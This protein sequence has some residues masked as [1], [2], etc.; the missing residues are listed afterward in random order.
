MIESA[1][2][3][4]NK[5]IVHR[6]GCKAEGEPLSISKSEMQTAEYE[7]V[8]DMLKC[9]FFKPFK[10]EA[11]FN[12]THDEGIEM[13]MV[14]NHVSEIFDNP[15]SFHEMSINIASQLYECSTHAKIKGGEFYMAYFTDCIVDGEL[16]D[17]IGI[18]KSENKEMFLKVYMSSDENIGLGAQEGISIRKLDKGCIIFN[19]ER[20]DGYR[21]CAVDNINKGQE[22]RFWM[23]DFLGLTPRQDNYFFTDNYMQLCKGFVKDVFNEQNNVRRTDQIELIN[24]SLD[25]FQHTPQFNHEDFQNRVMIEPDIMQAFD[26]YK[27]RY[28]I[29]NKVPKP[30]PDAFDISKDAVKSEKKHFK[31]IIKLD[32]NF[33]I[34]I[35]GG[36]YMMEKDY[37]AEKDLN[38]YKLYF[39]SES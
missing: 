31:T 39:K 2:A 28:E 3:K 13:N 9:F 32:K 7:E 19:V 27:E 21:V 29:D 34:Y 6:I 35:H 1:N 30:L 33:H 11:Y 22:A 23:Q 12:M 36:R 18:F 14:Y 26:E 5:L 38:F 24:R 37:D 10:S 4:I 15:D 8:S 17:A 16:C 25:F 20:E